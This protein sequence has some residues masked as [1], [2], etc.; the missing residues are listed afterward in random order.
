MGDTRKFIGDID[1]S[2]EI[3]ED[4]GE[5]QRDPEWEIQEDAK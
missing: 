4:P 2:G 5:I 3:Q 1:R